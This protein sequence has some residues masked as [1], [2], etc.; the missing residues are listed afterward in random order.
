MVLSGSWVQK[1]PPPMAGKRA[2]CAMVCMDHPGDHSQVVP[3][4]DMHGL[5]GGDVGG[6][7]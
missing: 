3:G 4:M 7:F 5:G 1:S 2:L 6:Q